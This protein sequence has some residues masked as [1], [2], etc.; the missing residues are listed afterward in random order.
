MSQ[1]QPRQPYRPP[2]LKNKPPSQPS[3]AQRVGA[4]SKAKRHH[5][6]QQ[7]QQQR[8]LTNKQARPSNQSQK[9]QQPPPRPRVPVRRPLGKKESLEI[10]PPKTV[11]VEGSVLLK[12]IK[13][14]SDPN[15]VSGTLLGFQHKSTLEV[16]NCFPAISVNKQSKS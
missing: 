11:Q 8:P 14:G 15:E 10:S 1:Q 9:Q 7:P 3:L 5:P 6:Q 16:T 4:A 2:G 12:I 13:H